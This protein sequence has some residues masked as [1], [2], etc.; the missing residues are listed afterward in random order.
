MDLDE[1]IRQGKIKRIFRAKRKLTHPN[2]VSH[3]TQRAA[4][5]DP[6]FLE[7]DDYLFMLAN[8]KD[9]SKRTSLDV[10]AFCLM[11]NHIHLLV[12]PHE[13]ELHVPMRD[14]FSRYAMWF[15]KKYERRGHLFGGPYRQS[16]CLDDA[17]LLAVSLYIHMNPV[18]AGLV[19]DPA[20][21]RWSSV[22]LY[23]ND[24]APSSFINSGFVLRLLANDRKTQKQVYKDLMEKSVSFIEEDALE[25]SNAVHKLKSSLV[26]IF[27]SVFSRIVKSRQIAQ[28]AG[29]DVLDEEELNRRINEFKIGYPISSPET[30][31]AKR[32]LIEQLIARGYKRDEIAA[33]IGVSVKTVYNIL[34]VVT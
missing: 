26:G 22:R 19:N 34:K 20:E 21:Y 16:V 7:D 13:D 18:R 8:L 14:L 30:I 12:S 27:P 28:Y 15:N 24:N 25:N 11:P 23:N 29:L 5:K 9:T 31:K 3:I 10:Y 2:L 1:L 6:L 17:Y 4:G 33:R 32:F